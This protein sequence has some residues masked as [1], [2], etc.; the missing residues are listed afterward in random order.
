MPFSI[1]YAELFIATQ[2]V[3][4]VRVRAVGIG[5][6]GTNRAFA[7]KFHTQFV[8]PIETKRT[9]ICFSVIL[10]RAVQRAVVLERVSS[11]TRTRHVGLYGIGNMRLPRPA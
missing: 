3:H 11:R 10:A 8:N 7:K 2:R 9:A 4:A 5:R 1:Y 6:N